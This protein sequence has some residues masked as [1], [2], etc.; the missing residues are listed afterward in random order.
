MTPLK[1]FEEYIDQGI[2]RN[3]SIN[4]ERAKSLLLES[5]RKFNSL[6]ERTEKLSVKD[7]NANDYIEYC[8]DLPM[9]LVRAKLYCAGYC[10]SGQGAHEAEVSYLIKLDF[11][12]K[13]LRFMDQLRYFRNGILYYGTR[14]DEE[15]AK[16][17][18]EFTNKQYPRLKEIVKKD[19]EK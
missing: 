19:L 18:I 11:S 17:V 1:K 13:E 3:V 5:E 15:Y 14:L 16:K 9:H 2:M 12:E 10:A 6:K 8:Y 4:K 7:D